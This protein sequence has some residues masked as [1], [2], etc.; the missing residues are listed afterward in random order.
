MK[1]EAWGGMIMVMKRWACVVLVVL[2]FANVELALVGCKRQDTVP[3]DMWDSP[4]REVL[5]VTPDDA[6][7][8]VENIGRVFT[9]HLRDRCDVEVVREGHAWLP[10]DQFLMS[11]H[12]LEQYVG[13]VQRFSSPL[14]TRLPFLR[15]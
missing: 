11:C 2:V 1:K 6:P 4:V 5:L 13:S 3:Q 8:E 15:S 12:R 7:A 9:R 14:Y 10:L